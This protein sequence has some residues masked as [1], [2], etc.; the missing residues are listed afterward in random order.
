MFRRHQPQRK[1]D[2]RPSLWRI[3]SII[4]HHPLPPQVYLYLLTRS[5]RRTSPVTIRTNY[6][7]K[8]AFPQTR[9]PAHPHTRHGAGKPATSPNATGRRRNCPP[10]TCLMRSPWPGQ[11]THPRPHACIGGAN[12]P[13]RTPGTTPLT[14]VCCASAMQKAAAA[15]QFLPPLL[16]VS[17]LDERQPPDL[18]RH[19]SQLSTH[20]NS[21]VT[22]RTRRTALR[23]ADQ[24]RQCANAPMP[25]EPVFAGR[26]NTRTEMP[27]FH[28]RTKT[29][30]RA[31]LGLDNNPIS[32]TFPLPTD[33]ALRNKGRRNNRM[34]TNTLRITPHP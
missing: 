10:R 9:K 32:V 23:L 15:I 24:Q 14:A 3:A 34:H 25:E 18:A 27:V 2:M 5:T 16:V 4:V 19:P 28:F 11:R 13:L 7:Y 33:G 31:H 17:G 12:G 22:R 8:P 1:I 26:H 20:K 6:G 21:A 29:T 30:A